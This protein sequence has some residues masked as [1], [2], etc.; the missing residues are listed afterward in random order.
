MKRIFSLP[1][2]AKIIIAIALGIAMSFVLPDFAVRITNTFSALF[3]Q[4][5]GFIIPFIIIGLVTPAI[6][7]LGE[8]AGRML[9]TTALIA[10]AFTIMSGLIA[11]GFSTTLFPA[12]IDSGA[13]NIFSS[14]GL[15]FEPLFTLTIPPIMDVMTA[16]V[17]SFMLGIGI[18]AFKTNTLKSA[19]NELEHIVTGTIAKIIIPLLPLFIFSLFLDMA[20]SGKVAPIIAAFIKIIGIIGVMTIVLLIVQ[21]SIAGFV[22]RRNPLKLLWGMLPAYATALGTSSSAATIPITL[23][24]VEKL[25]VRH[26][27]AGF[28][29]PLCATIHLSGSMLKITSCTI[30]LMIMLGMPID[31][32]TLLKFIIMLSVVMAAAPGVPGGAIMAALGILGS[33]IGFNDQQQGMMIAL[34]VAMDSFG[35]ACNVTGDGSIAVIVNRIS[36]NKQQ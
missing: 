18:A 30:A 8:G 9:G 17:A 1:L 15:K 36:N 16:L 12:I 32:A 25:G 33:I 4:L 28:V 11:I 21:Y 24:Q 26:E 6:A 7:N 29:V 2:L 3:S 14:E 5:L 10:Y 13:N 31:Y 27:I 35:T 20:A 22:S 34:Y 23:K 19:F